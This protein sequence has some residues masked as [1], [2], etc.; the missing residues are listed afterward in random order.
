[1]C[2]RAFL[3]TTHFKTRHNAPHA[4]NA[5]RVENLMNICMRACVATSG[6]SG[7]DRLTYVCMKMRMA[8]Y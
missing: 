5:V 1:M 2:G 3:V 6:T 7:R 8:D 4:E